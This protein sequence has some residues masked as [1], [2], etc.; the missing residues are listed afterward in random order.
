M[1]R[2][3]QR[4]ILHAFG[5]LTTTEKRTQQTSARVDTTA[6]NTANTSPNPECS[7]QHD[8]AEGEVEGGGIRFGAYGS[9]KA[10]RAHGQNKGD[11]DRK[12][13]ER[14]IADAEHS[15]KDQ[16]SEDICSERPLEAALALSSTELTGSATQPIEPSLS[17]QLH[18]NPAASRLIYLDFDG[19]TTA[20]TAWNTNSGVESYNSPAYDIDGDSTSFSTTELERIQQIWQRVAS[21]FAPFDVDVTT[22]AP[23]LDWLSRSS[24]N[25]TTYGMRVV[26]TS[27]G[28]YYGAGGVSYIDSF[29][30]A[31]DSPAF[32]YKTSLIN[33]A[34]TISHE[35]GHTLGLSHDGTTTA[36]YYSGHGSGEEGW[37]PIMGASTSQNI[38][39]WDDGT[40]TGS[41]NGGANANGG[42]GPDDLYIISNYNGFSYRPDTE[43]DGM[44]N[45]TPLALINGSF[46]Q[47]ATIETRNDQ[48]Y[49]AFSMGSA[50]TLS[51]TADPYWSRAFVDSDGIWGG[52]VSEQLG[53]MSDLDP[54]T[55]WIDHG[56]NLDLCVEVLDA[57][58]QVVDQSNPAG[59]RA[60]FD[61]LALQAGNYCVRIDGVGSGDPTS[62]TPTGYSDYSSIGNYW[63]SGSV[64]ASTQPSP[65]DL[66]TLAAN[67]SSLMEGNSGGATTFRLNIN[68]SA[69]ASED[70][71]LS[72]ATRDGTAT[73]KGK[74]IDYTAI[75]NGQLVIPKGQA[76]GSLKLSI[77]ADQR[78]E[79]NESFYVDFD[80][81]S[82]AVLGRSGVQVT[83]L[84]DDILTNGS[85]KKT[86]VLALASVD[87][88]P[89]R[90]RNHP[91]MQDGLTGNRMPMGSADSQEIRDERIRKGMNLA[92]ICE[93]DSTIHS[94]ISATLLVGLGESYEQ[95]SEN[96]LFTAQSQQASW[97][98]GN[99]DLY[100]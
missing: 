58:G 45:A 69:V 42:K 87:R 89:A 66:P 46:N 64:T 27:N 72:F 65:P 30:W 22:Q 77:N 97:L 82:G 44:E 55:S 71:V 28:P 32:V 94:G 18:S 90:R 100:V 50:G 12:Q 31:S 76:D 51:L 78:S 35:V 49:F 81:I 26:I 57:S 19:H 14:R 80:T 24:G 92:R 56:S 99:P 13:G 48:D 70:V 68:L 3:T 83:I 1:A 37:A 33:V 25:D 38:S 53:A 40:Y 29:T 62:A 4:Q 79:A 43:G 9:I 15:R 74:A 39:T 41:N 95:C 61:S 10:W 16:P 6:S 84:N 36:A 91:R 5:V 85:N 75:S 73:S 8:S 11:Q 21:D 60:G 59:L 93:H 34:E 98:M 88:E 67:D 17:F 86:S 47:F 96:P 7:N 63:L 23:P 52:S 54:T 2:Q 20:G